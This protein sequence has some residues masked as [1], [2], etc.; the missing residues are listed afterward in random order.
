MGGATESALD[1]EPKHLGYNL[2]CATSKLCD[3]MT[4]DKLLNFSKP[5]FL[6][7]QNGCMWG[8]CYNVLNAKVS[9][10]TK[11][12]HHHHVLMGP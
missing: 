5:Q 11:S 2:R 7:V 10:R 6:R 9:F 4:S 3:Y 1:Q 12:D 8:E